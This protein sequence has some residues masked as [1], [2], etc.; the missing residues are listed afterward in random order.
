MRNEN[1]FNVATKKKRAAN[2]YE[3][4]RTVCAVMA[5]IIQ[6]ALVLIYLGAL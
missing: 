2:W 1:I 3:K 5:V 4:I 6:T